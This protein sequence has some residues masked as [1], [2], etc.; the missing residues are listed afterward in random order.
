MDLMLADTP[1]V[2]TGG[3]RGIGRALA[4]AF[5]REGARVA[6][7][8]RDQDALAQTASL[9]RDAGAD[10]LTVHADLL[11]AE[12]CQKV[13]DEAAAQFGSLKV[14]VNNA[15][16]SADKTPRFLEEASDGQIME[17]INGKLLAAVRCSRAAIPHMRRAGSGRIIHIGGTAARSVFRA[18]E[19]P[20]NGSGLPQ[21]L[22]NAAL[23]N[24]SKH[25][26]EEVIG[27]KIMVN[28][29]HPHVTR[30][31]RHAARVTRKAEELGVSE[32]EA[33]DAIA[34]QFPL[35][36]IIE[37]DDITP[38][39]LFLASPLA[40]AITGQAIAVDGGAARSIMY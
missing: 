3:S 4:V 17:R 10:C 29:V 2:I 28:V 37:V 7:C 23:S 34:R 19:V 20:G 18:G 35:G 27:A 13:V 21:G 25:L 12:D 32:S 30:T 40:S 24:F 5:A 14:L 22:G 1:V 16:S 36:R 31:D 33:D 9:V 11:R 39:V 15:S 26:S 8:G 6:I 38:L